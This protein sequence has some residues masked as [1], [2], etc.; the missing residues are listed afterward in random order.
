MSEQYSDVFIHSLVNT[1]A[2]TNPRFNGYLTGNQ[3][4]LSTLKNTYKEI[5]FK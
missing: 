3:N 4:G 5:Y 2:T 1:E